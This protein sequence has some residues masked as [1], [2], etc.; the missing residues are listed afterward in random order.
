MNIVCPNCDAE[1]LFQPEKKIVGQ[2]LRCSNCTQSWFQYNLP[3]LKIT[4]VKETNNLKTMALAEYKI[5]EQKTTN[6]IDDYLKKTSDEDFK[7]RLQDSSERLKK[8]KQ[9]LLTNEDENNDKSKTVDKSTIIGFSIV[10][11][12]S[13]SCLILYVYNDTIQEFS[14]TNIEILSDYKRLVDESIKTIHNLIQLSA[15]LLI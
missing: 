5:S 8:N 11:L 12:I 15:Q 7:S 9:T 3:E 4:V 13:I 10:S 1:Y 6:K 14:S 2:I